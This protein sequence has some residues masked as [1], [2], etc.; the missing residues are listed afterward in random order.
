MQ[1][2]PEE[3]NHLRTYTEIAA[4]LTAREAEVLES[5]LTD[6]SET[7]ITKRLGMAA[8][9]VR[10]HMSSIREK[11]GVQSRAELMKV[12]LLAKLREDFWTGLVEFTG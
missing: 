9:T 2:K 6:P 10:N 11:L 4:V 8:Q 1:W 7:H 12:A 3:P 5:F